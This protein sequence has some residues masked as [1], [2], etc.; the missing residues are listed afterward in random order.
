MKET[1]RRNECCNLRG[2][3]QVTRSVDTKVRLVSTEI[4]EL[5]GFTL[6]LKM[7]FENYIESRYSRY[8]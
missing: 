6:W 8:K 5:I 4:V 2:Q 7:T 1:L 3:G